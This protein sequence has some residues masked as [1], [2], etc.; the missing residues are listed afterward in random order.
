MSVSIEF[1][2]TMDPKVRYETWPEA[3]DVPD[4]GEWVDLVPRGGDG[5]AG[6]VGVV[7]RRR[8][9]GQGKV[10]MIDVDIR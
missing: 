9:Y 5:T 10:V 3:G 7:R 1:R 8:W 6:V 4:V 2:W